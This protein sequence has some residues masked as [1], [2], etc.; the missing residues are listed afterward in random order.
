MNIIAR[1]VDYMITTPTIRQ[2]LSVKIT[3]RWTMNKSSNNDINQSLGTSRAPSD[4]EGMF[5][6]ICHTTS[7]TTCQNA[8]PR[9]R[10]PLPPATST[11]F[12]SWNITP[13]R[14]L[15]CSQSR[16]HPAH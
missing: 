3:Y 15:F 12:P 10:S 1:R 8:S 16:R 9:T 7:I 11:A 4:V 13:W 5:R 14:F 2:T 6:K